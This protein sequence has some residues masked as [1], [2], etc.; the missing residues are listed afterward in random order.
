MVDPELNHT[1]FLTW[2]FGELPFRF[3]ISLYN[4]VDIL[5]AFIFLGMFRP[6]YPAMVDGGAGTRMDNINAESP[7]G[8]GRYSVKSYELLQ[9]INLEARHTPR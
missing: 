9:I 4:T 1:F 7:N 5:P 8:S 3:G 2:M 6:R